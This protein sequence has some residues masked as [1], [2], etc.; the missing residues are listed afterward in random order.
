[1]VP[2]SWWAPELRDCD[3]YILSINMYLLYG[4]F[5]CDKDCGFWEAIRFCAPVLK[6]KEYP[7][8]TNPPHIVI[9]QLLDFF[10][11][12]WGRVTVKNKQ[13]H[14]ELSMAMRNPGAMRAMPICPL[15]P[16]GEKAEFIFQFCGC[17]LN[18]ERMSVALY[19]NF[20]P[21]WKGKSLWYFKTLAWYFEEHGGDSLP[22][23]LTPNLRDSCCS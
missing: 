7:A 3:F 22:P 18:C 16:A 8:W 20:Y 4:E 1:M 13:S 2:H 14:M 19:L 9:P 15:S 6:P 23:W 5:H 17:R 21:F 10:T 12:L 11:G